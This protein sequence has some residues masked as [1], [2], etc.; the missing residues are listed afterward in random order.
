MESKTNS[1]FLFN[2]P[3]YSGPLEA[4]LD[5]AKNQ[6]VDLANISITK[7]SRSIFRIY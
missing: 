4:L 1:V 7:V 2:I 5:L 6:K 3:N